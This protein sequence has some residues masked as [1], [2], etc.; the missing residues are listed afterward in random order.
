MI[1][2]IDASNEASLR[3]HHRLGFSPCGSIREAGRKFDR[4]LDLQLVQRLLEPAS[5]GGAA[6]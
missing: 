2:V 5:T 4:W 1:G 6:M 3:L